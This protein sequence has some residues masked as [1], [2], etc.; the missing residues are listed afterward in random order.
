M[1]DF[2]KK[3]DF[4]KKEGESMRIWNRLHDH[5]YIY[6]TFVILLGIIHYF[7]GAQWLQ[8]IIGLFAIPML[9]L[10]F[11]KA[12]KLFK[13]LGSAFIVFGFL[14][15]ISARIPFHT[16]PLL[17][18]SNMALLGFILVLPWINS[19]VH[20]GHYG[21]QINQLMVSNVNNLGNFY[22]KSTVTSYILMIFLNLS[23]VTVAQ[24]VLKENLNKLGKKV[25]DS[26]ISKTTVRAFTLALIWSPMEVIV[27][28]T[29]GATGVDYLQ[30]L[31]YLLLV[32]F[33]SLTLDVIVG[34]QRLKRIPF[35]PSV[36]KDKDIPVGKIVKKLIQLFIALVLFLIVIVVVSNLFNWNFI[37]TVTMVIIPF[38]IIWALLIKRWQPF[39]ILGFE[40]WKTQTNNMQNFIVLFTTLSFF[41]NSLNATTFLGQ[42][43]R[44]FMY[45]SDSPFMIFVLI[46]LTYFLMSLIGVHPVGVIAILV[47]LLTP[48]FSIINPSSIAIVLIVSSL[49][50]SGSSSYGVVVTLTS[51]NTNQNPYLITLRNLPFTF[52]Y[53]MIGI[54][55]AMLI[56]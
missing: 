41:S 32:S 49:A 56:L 46:L 40:L 20:V 35:E 55:I 5:L 42:V 3:Y 2:A 52:V 6:Y 37:I 1:L 17:L 29:I 54:A 24:D 39:K 27:A 25:R 9:I 45:F 4:S 34:R 44:P 22:V 15:F 8:Y 7:Y 33:L 43:Q 23:G 30:I 19:V 11:R 36:G 26:F 28:I 48:I 51:L 16:I 31:P 12:T 18:T 14:F 50:T 38:S 47:E 13:I 21:K 53:G 10:S